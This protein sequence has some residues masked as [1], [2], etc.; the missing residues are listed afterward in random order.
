MRVRKG[1]LVEVKKG[2]DAWDP[3]TRHGRGRVLKV[4]TETN[5]VFVEGIRMIVKHQ[6]KTR[7]N[8]E[9]GRIR[10]EAPIDVSNVMLVC[11]KCDKGVRTGYRTN[12]EG[13]KERCCKACGEGIPGGRTAK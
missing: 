9:G 7:D 10:K 5:R 3:A 6:R 1:D 12:A 8:P 11:P 4:L 2:S 13:Q